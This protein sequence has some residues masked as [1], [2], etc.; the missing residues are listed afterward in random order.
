MKNYCPSSNHVSV[1]LQRSSEGIKAKEIFDLKQEIL[2]LSSNNPTRPA[3]IGT[4]LLG[5]RNGKLYRKAGFS[6]FIDFI[7]KEMPFSRRTAYNYMDL[8]AILGADDFIQNQGIMPSKLIA[9]LP[10]LKS[11]RSLHRQSELKAIFLTAARDRTAREVNYLAQRIS[12]QQ[13]SVNPPIAASENT[14]EVSTDEVTINGEKA[15]TIHISESTIRRKFAGLIRSL[16]KSPLKEFKETVKDK[17]YEEALIIL[18]EVPDFVIDKVTAKESFEI[19]G[20]S[21]TDS[22][23]KK[24]YEIKHQGRDRYVAIRKLRKRDIYDIPTVSLSIQ[25]LLSG[26]EA[27]VREYLEKVTATKSAMS[28]LLYKF[29]MELQKTRTLCM[30]DSD[31]I[32]LLV[33]H[34]A[35]FTVPV[36]RSDSIFTWAILKEY[37][38]VVRYALNSMSNFDF[39]SSNDYRRRFGKF[40]KD[41]GIEYWPFESLYDYA[42]AAAPPDIVLSMIKK[43]FEINEIS[44]ET[45]QYFPRETCQTI[46][47]YIQNRIEIIR[48]E[49]S[50]ISD[51]DGRD[52][53]FQRSRMGFKISALEDKIQLLRRNRGVG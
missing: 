38:D 2:E 11:V 24:G 16:S 47:N 21:E 5:I 14:V 33:R 32:A 53:I 10:L 6:T 22:W 9:A 31:I 43:G 35:R 12:I 49:M 19:R 46:S 39:L 20:K 37:W 30:A 27:L 23:R 13:Q 18:P 36:V 15:F 44:N 45:L 4:M 7:K 52:A 28:F 48:K 41:I 50:A 40:N 25:I 3:K 51:E 8:A 29:I 17:R 26:H 34:D 1:G 42:M